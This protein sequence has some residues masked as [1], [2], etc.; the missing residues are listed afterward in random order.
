MSLDF[1]SFDGLQINLWT[2]AQLIALALLFLILVRGLR[3]VL[4]LWPM[5]ASRRRGIEQAFPMVELLMV[6]LYV[7]SAVQLLFRQLPQLGAIAVLGILFGGMWIGRHALMDLL[8]GVFLRT[9]GS[10]AKGDRVQIDGL[11]GHVTWVGSQAL[12]IETASGDEALVPYSRLAGKAVVRTPRVDGAH[13]HTF[14]LEGGNGGSEGPAADRIR[15]LALLC[16]WSSVGR[17]P[18]VTVTEGGDH[19]VTVFA[20]QPERGPDIEAFVRKALGA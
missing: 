10:V 2:F 20:L 14:L 19:E 15:Q 8:T 12:G 11:D 16:H 5:A 9:S 17:P 18:V 13:R 7:V 1:E 3:F 4:R 6:L